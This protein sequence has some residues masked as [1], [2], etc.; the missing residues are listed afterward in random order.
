M[1]KGLTLIEVIL[2]IL[3]FSVG[4]LGLAAS[5]AST[6]RQISSNSLRSRAA[7]IALSRAETAQGSSCAAASSGTVSV[8]GIRSTWTV[9]TATVTTLDQRL[10]R[11]DSRGVH[12]DRFLSAIR[13]D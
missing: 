13:C 8:P 7:A 9:N 2:A 4:G 12:S 10:E 11:S 3:I 5:A 6:A 1:R